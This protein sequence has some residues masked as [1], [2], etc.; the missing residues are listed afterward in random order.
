MS[1]EKP[2]TSPSNALPQKNMPVPS[3]DALRMEVHFRFRRECAG[4]G[5]MALRTAVLA[6]LT[7]TKQ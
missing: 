3:E 4:L 6:Y 5:Y 2:G 1:N 7:G